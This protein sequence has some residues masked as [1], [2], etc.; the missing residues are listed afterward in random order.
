MVCFDLS[1]FK[2]LSFG[3]AMQYKTDWNTFERI[4]DYNSNVS[5]SRALGSTGQTYY[6]YRS[7]DEKISFTN[8][9]NLHY[10]RYPDSN[11]NAVQKN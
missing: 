11:W 8:G 5:T 2:G 4:Q 3:T 1:G 6:I 7:G 9:Q 10:R